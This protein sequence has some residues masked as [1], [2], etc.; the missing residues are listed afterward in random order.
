MTIESAFNEI[1]V[2]QGGTASTSGTIAGA[3][4]ALNDALA[5]SD[6]QA[7]VTIE[8]AIKLLGEHIN[9]GGGGGGQVDI[10]TPV[11]IL[12]ADP[13]IAVD[14]TYYP[15]GG[16]EATL[17]KIMMG[18]NLII[19]PVDPANSISG[20]VA[21]GL[22]VYTTPA[23]IVGNPSFYILTVS[24]NIVTA[25]EDITSDIVYEKVD[26]EYDESQFVFDVPD[27]NLSDDEYFAISFAYA[28]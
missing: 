12:Y 11:A 18:E 22:T 19:Q 2:A 14:D 21:S 5:G 16:S 17:K 13:N 24:D 15:E 20:Y 25:I 4:D 27:L 9:G 6:Q 28:D 1:A 7:A 8:D 23:V 10:G 26:L 3:I